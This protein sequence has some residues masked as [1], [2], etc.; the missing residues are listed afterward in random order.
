M[1]ESETTSSRCAVVGMAE[2]IGLIGVLA[3]NPEFGG[4]LGFE[5]AGAFAAVTYRYYGGWRLDR[6]DAKALTTRSHHYSKGHNYH[7]PFVGIYKCTAALYEE[8]PKL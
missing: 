3:G 6:L 5:L 7:Q 2:Y 1:N 4:D 8:S